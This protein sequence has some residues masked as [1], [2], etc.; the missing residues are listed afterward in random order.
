MIDR[1]TSSAA[2]VPR[3]DA[4]NREQRELATYLRQQ[5][6]PGVD[7]D[8]DASIGLEVE[9]ARL[10]LFASGAI[11]AFEVTQL[12]AATRNVCVTPLYWSMGL[13]CVAIAGAWIALI[14]AEYL[15]RFRV[16][17]RYDIYHGELA[18]YLLLSE[19]GAPAHAAANEGLRRLLDEEHRRRFRLRLF[20]YFA[21][22]LTAAGIV[23]GVFC[24]IGTADPGQC[25]FELLKPQM[26]R[27]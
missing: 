18:A 23:S 4:R 20:R 25:R 7:A 11:I 6:L 21:A 17:R 27:H 8:D 3:I 24:A 15:R 9:Q 5:H 12:L 2:S 13:L 14:G 19:G 1:S 22:L 10:V 16:D 26:Q